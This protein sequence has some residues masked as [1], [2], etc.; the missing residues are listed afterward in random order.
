VRSAF[1]AAEV[2]AKIAMYAQFVA[3]LMGRLGRLAA[4]LA[5]AGP[6]LAQIRAATDSERLAGV[7]AFITNLA[8]SRQLAD[9]YTPQ[10]AADACWALTSPQLYDQLT[11]TRGW[12]ADIYR[13]WL[14]DT[15][16]A[17]LSDSQR[18]RGQ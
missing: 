12:S 2:P 1:A 18:S 6:E 8:E 14:T 15:L 9:R 4:V 5:A 10:Q 7:S 13:T 11:S 16:L 3:D 17:V